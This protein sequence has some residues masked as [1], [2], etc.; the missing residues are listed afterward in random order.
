M[1]ADLSLWKEGPMNEDEREVLERSLAANGY[2]LTGEE[3]EFGHRIDNVIDE[4]L[5]E[6]PCSVE[7]MT[8]KRT[9]SRRDGAEGSYTHETAV[10]FAREGGR[11]LG[12]ARRVIAAEKRGAPI[13]FRDGSPLQRGFGR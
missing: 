12:E 1:N 9:F 4:N 10:F 7:T 13:S 6:I 2:R 3:A 11:R 8:V 5:Q